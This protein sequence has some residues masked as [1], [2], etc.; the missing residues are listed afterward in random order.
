MIFIAR[1]EE[2]TLSEVKTALSNIV[3]VGTSLFLVVLMLIV[4]FGVT[5][6]SFTT[7]FNHDISELPSISVGTVVGDLRSRL[8]IIHPSLLLSDEEVEHGQWMGRELECRILGVF[9]PEVVGEL[10]SIVA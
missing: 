2:N 5:S 10:A 1:F 3:T 6:I 7:L 4:I 9:F 8:R